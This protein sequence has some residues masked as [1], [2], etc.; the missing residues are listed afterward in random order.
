MS[1]KCALLRTKMKVTPFKESNFFFPS[2]I[3][4][5][6]SFPVPPQLPLT[7]RVILLA[8]RHLLLQRGSWLLH[9][10]TFLPFH[11]SNLQYACFFFPVSACWRLSCLF[12]HLS[13]QQLV[14]SLLLKHSSLCPSCLF[15]VVLVVCCLTVWFQ[16]TQNWFCNPFLSQLRDSLWPLLLCCFSLCCWVLFC[17]FL[18][19]PILSQSHLRL[20][21]FNLNFFAWGF[22]NGDP[23]KFV[24]AVNMN[25]GRRFIRELIQIVPDGRTVCV[26]VCV[27][28]QVRTVFA[29]WK[30]C[31][32]NI[33]KFL[34]HTWI[35]GI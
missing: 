9:P 15:C 17:F 8:M 32:Q 29:L 30:K 28:M 6:Q 3:I 25:W 26:F 34:H 21:F 23:K 16:F 2:D 5:L 1:L 14:M 31:L 19:P 24:T 11:A 20:Y 13:I 35:N 7:F 33:L 4:H 18:F 27:G 22:Q 12:Y 10:L